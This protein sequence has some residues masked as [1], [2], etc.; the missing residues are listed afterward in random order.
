MDISYSK[1]KVNRSYYEHK[2][3]RVDKSEPKNREG[4]SA[5]KLDNKFSILEKKFIKKVDIVQE[6]DVKD[7]K[8]ETMKPIII[9]DRE[10]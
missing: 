9:M 7:V 3:K 4:T 6:Q 10:V 5:S 8:P 2:P 1:T